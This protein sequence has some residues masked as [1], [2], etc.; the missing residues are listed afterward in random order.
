MTPK[1]CRRC[2]TVWICVIF[3]MFVYLIAIR[4]VSGWYAALGILLMAAWGCK[5]GAR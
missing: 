1:T 5:D 3:A 2:G 4:H